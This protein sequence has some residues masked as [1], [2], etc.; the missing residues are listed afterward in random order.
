LYAAA[1]RYRQGQLLGGKAGESLQKEA[2]QVF[3]LQHI[4]KP[5]AWVAMLAPGF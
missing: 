3:H 2:S 1:A 5:E 4:V